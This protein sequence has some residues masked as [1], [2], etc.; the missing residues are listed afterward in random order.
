MKL[1]T[2]AAKR[3]G[4]SSTFPTFTNRR[5]C[6]WILLK[7]GFRRRPRL[8][9]DII[10]LTGDFITR[11]I[12]DRIAYR[13][14][15]STL[16]DAAPTFACLGN[17][18]GGRWAGRHGG[19]ATPDAVADILGESGAVILSDESQM[20]AVGDANVRLIGIGDLWSQPLNLEPRL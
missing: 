11:R 19:Y 6:R 18:D 8:K 14:A 16:A 2:S 15:L 17:H 20:I 9:P 3:R 13:R 1:L 10:C 5:R 4:E 12:H 7:R